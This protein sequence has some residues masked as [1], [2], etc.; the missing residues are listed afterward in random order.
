MLCALFC[1]Y[2][3]ALVA[4]PAKPQF[5]TV[6]ISNTEPRRDVTGAIVDAH[7]G[8]ILFADGRYYLYGTA[9]GKSAGFGI[10]NRFRIY[11]SPDLEHW[12]FEGEALKAPPDGVYYNPSVVY[13]ARSHKYV[14]WYNWYPKLWDGQVGVAVSDTPIG[15][16]TI[17]DRKVV[18]TQSDQ[19]PGAGTLFV[20]D[21]GTGYYIYNAIGAN[22]GT[23]K[24][25]GQPHHSVRVERLT[26]DFLR[27]TGKVS[28]VIASGCEATSMLKHDNRYYALFD[29]TCC[30]CKE[31]SGARVYVA[32]SP[33]G[34]YVEKG[35]I[36]RGAD[37]APIVSGQQ[38][39]IARIPTPEGE[40]L[41]WIAD[42]WGSRPDGVKGHDFQ[43][44]SAPLRFDGEGNILPIENLS[45]WSLK[46]RVGSGSGIHN[47]KPYVWPRKKDPHPL[48]IDP[49][50]QTPLAPED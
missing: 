19:K 16:F 30:F 25:E 40:A 36:N 17:V 29:S 45:Q 44:W 37:R 6:T 38:A 7:D 41:I 46:V 49:C 27:S 13:N 34:P 18:L 48:A 22:F 43:F 35:N 14:F 4:A 24:G 42:R 5:R 47:A 28:D 21:D 50:T 9:Y 32:S 39:S 33:L 23:P 26:P 20:D 11:S 15:P 12:T 10:N 1:L 8:N 2:T 3:A 31:G